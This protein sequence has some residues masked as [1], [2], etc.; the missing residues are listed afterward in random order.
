MKDITNM[1]KNKNN[2]FQTITSKSSVIPEQQN[3]RKIH[4]LKYKIIWNNQFLYR[5]IRLSCH[6]NVGLWGDGTPCI[7]KVGVESF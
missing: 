5:D 3:Q 4:T 2:F 1:N 6:H 7:I